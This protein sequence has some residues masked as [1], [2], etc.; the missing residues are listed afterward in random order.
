MQTFADVVRLRAAETPDRVGYLFSADGEAV[1]NAAT[2][3]YGELDH[4]A[5]GVAATLT[6]AGLRGERAMLIYSAGLD[7]VVALFGCFFAGV[8]A[9]PLPVPHFRHSIERVRA[10]ASDARPA[11]VL[12]TASVRSSV[13]ASLA[14]SGWQWIATDL[15][16]ADP[17]A[18]PECIPH[19]LAVIQY[20]SGSTATPRG[21]MLDHANLIANSGVIKVRFGH[22][23]ESR[24]VSWLPPYHDMGLI[25]GLLQPAYV[26]FPMLLLS[27]TS[28]LRL[29]ARWLQAISEFRATTSGGPD[30]AYALCERRVTPEQRAG[31][32]L[33]SWRVAFSGAEQVRAQTLDAFHRAFAAQG[34]RR[35][36]LLPCY[37]LAEATL[38][39]TGAE[40]GAGPVVMEAGRRELELGQVVDA[41]DPATASRAIVSCGPPIP[42]HDVVVV[43]PDAMTL[44]PAGQVGEV[45]VSGPAVA[46]GYWERTVETAAIFQATLAEHAD[47]HYLRTGDL[48][49][50]RDGQLFVTGRLKDLIVVRGRNHAPEDIERTADASHPALRR[51]RGAAFSVEVDGEDQ[52]VVAVELDRVRGA[53]TSQAARSIR[54]AVADTHELRVDVVLLLRPGA[55]PTTS[56]GKVQRYACRRQFLDGTL[57]VVESSLLDEPSDEALL[58]EGTHERLALD[59]A[60][61]ALGRRLSHADLSSPLTALGIDSLGAI[62]LQHALEETVGLRVP[63]GSILD[64]V[65]LADIAEQIDAPQIDAQATTASADPKPTAVLPL[66]LSPGQRALWFL[67]RLDPHA[68]DY[69]IASAVRASGEFN[70]PAVRRAFR[71]LLDRHDVLRMTVAAEVGEPLVRVEPGRLDLVVSPAGSDDELLERLGNE[72]RVPFDLEKGPLLRI[73]VYVR[74]PQEHVL[75]VVIHHIVADLWSLETLLDEFVHLYTAF[76]RGEESAALPAPGPSYFAAV[77]QQLGQ[78][79]G[80]TGEALWEYWREELEGAPT[81]LD[82][83]IARTRQAAQ[84]VSGARHYFAIDEDLA[85]RVRALARQRQTTSYAVLL[86]AFL[87]LLHRYTGQDDILVGSPTTGRGH[88]GVSRT[89]GYFVNPVVLRSHFPPGTT[90]AESLE[91]LKKSVLGALDHSQLPFSTIVER[92][93]IRRD[94]ARSPLF[95]VMFNYVGSRQLV[96]ALAVGNGSASISAGRLTL[97]GLPFDAGIAQFDLALTVTDSQHGMSAA[98]DFRPDLYEATSIERLSGHLSALLAEATT[99][100]NRPIS[101]LTMVTEAEGRQLREWNGTHGDYPADVTVPELFERQVERDPDAIAIACGDDELSF[102]ELNRRANHVAWRLRALG[103]GPDVRVGLLVRTGTHALVDVFGILKAGGAYVPLDP[104]ESPHRLAELLREAGALVLVTEPDILEDL[105]P[106]PIPTVVLGASVAGS[107]EDQNPPAKA[108]PANLH[109]VIFTSGSTGRP[110]GVMVEHRSVVNLH[111]AIRQTI[112]D[113]TPQER[114]RIALLAPLFFDGSVREYLS[115][116]DGHLVDIVP[117]GIRRDGTRLLAHLRSRRVDELYCTPSQL[118]LLLAA[119]LLEGTGHVP[120]LV[121][122]GAEP[123]GIDLWKRLARQSRI[124]FYDIYGPTECTVDATLCAI[125]ESP[126]LPTIGRPLG[127]YRAYVLD[128]EMAPTPV[129]LPGEL[130]IGGAGVARGYAGRPVLTAECFVPDPFCD[131]PGQRLY[132]TG[133]VARFLPDGNIELLG[134]RDRQVKVRGF[135]VDSAELEAALRGISG[136]REA[137]VVVDED[138]TSGTRLVAYVTLGSGSRPTVGQVLQSLRE[139]LPAYMVPSALIWIDSLPLTPNGKIDYQALP[140]PDG[141]RPELE[142]ELVA[143][144]SQLEDRIARI[145]REVLGLSQVGVEDNFFDLGGTSL[146]LVRVQSVLG[147]ELCVDVP[148]AKLFQYPAVRSLAAYLGGTT[149]SDEWLDRARSLAARRRNRSKRSPLPPAAE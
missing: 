18:A 50:L 146:T 82:L 37:G 45:W 96:G 91:R 56:S 76:D 41:T 32:D 38:I 36:A 132:R 124:R 10:V 3:T 58:Q 88:A 68:A 93:N 69:N 148:V 6:A 136:I 49:F 100:P 28:F 20:T 25:G 27:P 77:R 65:T 117:P 22:S 71:S 99:H 145:W 42:G 92:L 103:V 138:A 110:K 78:L 62:R 57:G 63:L 19:E 7:L 139:E 143:P 83:P 14:D 48:G 59:A 12:S 108:S 134:R 141:A 101:R 47:R 133:D 102:A 26:G 70:L 67:H 64:G 16:D 130:H 8:T 135:R 98:F 75:Q 39:V 107:P 128:E 52:L 112:Y 35:E 86:T 121:L 97:T 85:T 21:V 109:H 15:V 51:C 73:R 60:S 31:L 5:R 87:V 81:L 89:V 123:I 114:L 1:R 79:A 34:F 33:S 149:A 44:C 2:L 4:R 144:A 13:R 55:L 137:T 9:V 147:Q 119:G 80:P 74:P 53:D 129:G 46:Q 23:A 115:L 126:D 113:N 11:A 125:D 66:V 95:Q 131:L 127:N 17:E 104:D 122:L 111:S 120:S 84:G 105:P 43:D 116:L 106:L 54:R 140:P 40:P 24:G 94:A 61:D 118:S 72:A 90:F 142:T 30:F 29:P